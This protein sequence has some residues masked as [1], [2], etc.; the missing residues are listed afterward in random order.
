MIEG[1]PEQC[2]LRIW[3]MESRLTLLK[4]QQKARRGS[5]QWKAS[6][7]RLSGESFTSSICIHIT[8][9][10]Y[11]D[12]AIMTNH[13]EWTSARGCCSNMPSILVSRLWCCLRKKQDSLGTELSVSVIHK[14]WVTKILAPLSNHKLTSI[15]NKFVGRH[16]WGQT[17]R[18]LRLAAK[19][20]RAFL[21]QLHN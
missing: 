20:D 19:V 12:C 7:S 15:L 2:V 14:F 17:D 10:K 8:Y 18:P 6:P 5:L 16:T 21:S 11:K 13:N 9:S 3:K 4:V 1:D